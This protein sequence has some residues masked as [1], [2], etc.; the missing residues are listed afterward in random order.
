MP[1]EFWSKVLWSDETKFELINSKRR[2]RCYKRRGEGLRPDTTQPTVKHS[3]GLMFW[4]C[5]SSSGVGALEEIPTTMDAKKYVEILNNN[6]I[7]SATVLG[8]KDNFVFQSDNDPKHTSKLATNWLKD[9]WVETLE[10][11]AQS[12]DLNIIEHLWE[13]VDRNIPQKQRKSM[14][15]FRSA[16]LQNW[17]NVPQSLIDSLIQSIPKRLQAVIDANGLNTKY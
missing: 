11:P 4:G 16:I 15:N 17:K 13:F 1:M 2:V 6:F 7:Q 8:I 10:W 12:P 3:K 5:V 14:E 9:N